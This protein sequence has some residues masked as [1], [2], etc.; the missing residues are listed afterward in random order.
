[1]P[2]K[3]ETVERK[4][5]TKP[6]HETSCSF[7]L[8]IKTP[9]KHHE[10]P[11]WPLQT[12]TWMGIFHPQNWLRQETSHPLALSS[13]MQFFSNHQNPFSYL[14]STFYNQHQPSRG[15]NPLN[16]FN[17]FPFRKYSSFATCLLVPTFHLLPNSN[18]SLFR[19]LQLHE[20]LP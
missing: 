1:M 9:L 15:R 12:P 20:C 18:L 7:Y 13:Q 3:L 5:C 4:C 11:E 16:R 19:F 6:N 2:S 8:Q 14:I 10:R 17:N